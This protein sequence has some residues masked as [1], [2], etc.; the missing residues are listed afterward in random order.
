[1][2]RSNGK[3]PYRV[4]MC[5]HKGA[6]VA[7]LC[8]LLMVQG[9]VLDLTLSHFA[10]AAQTGATAMVLPLGLTF[11]RFVRAFVS[12]R[13][14]SSLIVGVC[15]FAADIF[16]HPSHYP[17]AYTEAA[18]T[19]LGTTAA[20]VLISYTAIGKRIERLGDV[21]LEGHQAPPS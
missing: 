1:M 18:L 20:S 12:S 4:A 21:F 6:E 10:T 19:G 2:G 17:G 3:A 15:G 16:A 7:G 11:T 8:L 14:T 9:D 5:A 13:W